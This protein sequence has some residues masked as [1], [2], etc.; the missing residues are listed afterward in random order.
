MVLIEHIGKP[1]KKLNRFHD[2][3]VKIKRA[4]LHQSLLVKR[5]NLRNFFRKIIIC[6]RFIFLRPNQLVFSVGNMSQNRF[7]IYSFH[8]Q[9]HIL[10]HSFYQNLLIG[11]VVNPKRI[12]KIQK[13]N[14]FAQNPHTDR[15]KSSNTRN[16]TIII[17]LKVHGKQ[18]SNPIFH[19]ISGLICKSDRQNIP[20]VYSLFLN[21]PGNT[22]SQSPSLSTPGPGDH[23]QRSGKMSNRLNL[24][25]I[26]IF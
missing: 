12:L 13:L 10:N 19:L 15:V 17:P 7:R 22:M 6:V 26:Q 3:I 2:D 4:T 11:H 1:L 21:Q 24:L 20:R 25:I 5:I 16:R 8:V 23:K 14:M 18:S 9:I